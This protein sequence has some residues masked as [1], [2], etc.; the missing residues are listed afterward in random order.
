MSASGEFDYRKELKGVLA[1]RRSRNAGYSIRA[2]ARDLQVSVTALHGV[3]AGQRHLSKKN[4]EH[5]ALR[6]GWSSPKLELA[7]GSTYLIEDETES[8][9]SED[10]FSMIA[11]W[12]HLAILNL[13]NI[14]HTTTQSL[15]LRLGLEKAHCD[16]AVE[17][18]VRLGFIEIVE[19]QLIRKEPSF[20]TSQG[21]PSLAIRAFHYKNLHKAQ[22]ILET[23]PLEDRDFLTIAA[24]TN[25]TQI[26]EVKKM[27]QEF[28]KLVL[29]TLETPN[30][31]EVYFMNVQLY[32]V[33]TAKEKK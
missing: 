1:E 10:R 26:A 5:L 4:L 31:E 33:T 24:P 7:M 23:V 16:R 13:A 22:E 3:L 25:A 30:P 6:L 2:F 21:V 17:R 27:I 12:V 28:R 19:G 20:G 9:L 8:V 15:H 29:Q 32:P 14:P 18:L 11:D